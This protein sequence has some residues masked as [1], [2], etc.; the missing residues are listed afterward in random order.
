[1]FSVTSGLSDRREK[2]AGFTLIEMLVVLVITGLLAGLVGPSL[3]KLVQRGER[4]AQRQ[5][6]LSEIQSLGY[7]AYSDGHSIELQGTLQNAGLMA[8]TVPNG[9]PEPLLIPLGWKVEVRKTVRYNF[10][11][12]CSGG[13][14]NLITPEGDSESIELKGPRCGVL[15]A[16]RSDR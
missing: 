7:R 11:G 3:Y 4:A 9:L 8:E 5:S 15:T 16:S 1:M 14:L 10:N 6:L 13:E 12:M 2:Q